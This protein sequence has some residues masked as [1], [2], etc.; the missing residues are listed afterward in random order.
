MG[1]LTTGPAASATVFSAKINGDGSISGWVTAGVTALSA[2]RYGQTGVSANGAIYTIGGCTDTA[3]VCNTALAT[4]EYAA[5]SS[6][7]SL[8]AWTAVTSLPTATGFQTS[9]VLNGELYNFGGRQAGAPVTAV[10]YSKLGSNNSIGIWNTSSFPFPVARQQASHTNVNGY[11]YALGGF[12]G[13]TTLPASALY[14]SGARTLI[15][16]GLDLLGL[17]SQGLSDSGGGGALTAGNIRAVGELRVDGFADF[18]NGIS[19]DSA[20]NINAVSATAGQTVFNI[21]NNLSN[22]IFSIRHMNANFGSLV[23]AGA[24]EA[25]DSYF[26]EEYNVTQAT[27]T[28]I[29]GTAANTAVACS[30]ARGDTG[31]HLA[32]TNAA[33]S[34][35]ANS[36]SGTG[37]LSLGS[38]HGAANDQC[39]PSQPAGLNGVERITE[40]ATTTA[41]TAQC[42]EFLTGAGG[43]GAMATN[44]NA[45][46][47][48]VISFKVK[49]S[50]L[51]SSSNNRVYVGLAG[52]NGVAGVPNAVPGSAA[53]T[54]GA[55]FTNC[56]A[57][58]PTCANTTWYGWAINAGTA[59]VLTCPGTLSTTNFA[60]MR[61]EYRTATDVHFYIDVNTSDG[62]NEVE[63]G[64]GATTNVFA[65]NMTPWMETATGAASISTALDIDYYRAW[66]DDNMPGID[67]PA[68]Q[69]PDTTSTD[70]TP[71]TDSSTPL[72]LD[73]NSKA[74]ADSFF[75]FSAASSEDTVF[76]HD[77]YVKGTLYADKIKA[78][79]IEGLELL[80]NKISSLQDEVTKSQTNSPQ[81]STGLTSSSSVNFNNLQAVNLVALAQ[82]ESKG[83]LI[84]DKDA[85]FNGKT[86]F[87]LLA[88][89]NGNVNFKKQVTFNSDAGGLAVIKKGDQKVQIKYSSAYDQA[90]IVVANWATD[91]DDSDN[92][93]T[94]FQA[95]YDFLITKSDEKGFWIYL[96]KPADQDLKLNWIATSIKDAKITASDANAQ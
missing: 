47:L 17:S 76:N 85:T 20:V 62:I 70:T 80:T 71:A 18:N 61:I 54:G 46:N 53:S 89:F 39:V 72:S 82:I 74:D 27:N 43:V 10:L 8:G 31:G 40:N 12:D 93:A 68:V 35:T 63:C 56:S 16:G 28:T 77:V 48:P 26:G 37:E 13:T 1:G 67:T 49:P 84:V 87:Q 32:A 58:A 30:W 51:P 55:Y 83:G 14:T 66:Q 21:N 78:N 29:T 5:P 41:H 11:E 45:T 60:Y 65:G 52:F 96:N 6:T 92:Q 64:S 34:A 15:Y 9:A 3:G 81:S 36:N 57:V 7:G 73:T 38:N 44:Y 4:V 75:S 22:S 69:V 94:L 91:S 42:A 33:C 88:E 79:Q 2:A 25:H 86:I 50:T 95:G 90:P 24:F 59:T 23:K 19:V